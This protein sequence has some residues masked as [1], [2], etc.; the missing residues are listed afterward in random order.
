MRPSGRRGRGPCQSHHPA[1]ARGGT[2]P[3]RG[4]GAGGLGSGRRRAS[5]HQ[6]WLLSWRGNGGSERGSHLPK[7][8]QQGDGGGALALR[9]YS[10][11][12]ENAE[13][14]T[15]QDRGGTRLGSQPPKTLQR[16]PP[17]GPAEFQRAPLRTASPAISQSLS[18]QAVQALSQSR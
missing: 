5:D 18:S 7:V 16:R 8:T 3:G 12:S 11:A 4:P 15:A 10:S 2:S 14:S 1:G 9:A 6:P 17:A 13:P